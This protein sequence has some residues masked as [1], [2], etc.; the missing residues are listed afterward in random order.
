ME[1]RAPYGRTGSQ[2]HPP[3]WL[4][5]VVL[6]EIRRGRYA[7][8]DWHRDAWECEPV[9]W[10]LRGGVV[11]APVGTPSATVSRRCCLASTPRC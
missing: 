7:P 10:L 1:R 6:S 8:A 9:R 2:A 5:R 4:L 3:E 11:E